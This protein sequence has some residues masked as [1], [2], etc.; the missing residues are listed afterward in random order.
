MPGLEPNKTL[1]SWINIASVAVRPNQAIIAFAGSSP[2]RP[3]RHAAAG[4]DGG[5]P[6]EGEDILE[7]GDWQD[8][9]GRGCVALLARDHCL[10]PTQ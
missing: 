4:L 8:N 5:R 3:L 7:R 1:G 9:L 6:G 2:P 10:Y